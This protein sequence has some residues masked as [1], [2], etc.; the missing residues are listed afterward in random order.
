MHFYALFMITKVISAGKL[1]AGKSK[2]TLSQ[3]PSVSITVGEFLAQS[4]HVDSKNAALTNRRKF[5]FSSK[6]VFPLKI[7]TKC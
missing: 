6:M 5:S 4:W 1:N 7:K 2:M 3:V